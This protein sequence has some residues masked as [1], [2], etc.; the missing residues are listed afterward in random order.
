MLE[1]EPI[2]FRSG[3]H[4]EAVTSKEYEVDS[5]VVVVPGNNNKLFHADG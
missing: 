1:N 3:D 4:G 2:D 5:G